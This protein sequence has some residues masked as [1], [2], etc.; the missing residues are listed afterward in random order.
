MTS[1]R[2]TVVLE[3]GLNERA[4]K[5]QN[6]NVPYGPDEVAADLVA[7]M[8]HGA[9]LVHY[10]AATTTA[11]GVGTNPELSR[12]ALDTAA[13]R[14]DLIAYPSYVE[15]I[16]RTCST[17]PI[18]RGSIASGS[19]RST[20]PTWRRRFIRRRRRDETAGQAQAL[21]ELSRRGIVPNVAAFNIG[22]PAWSISACARWAPRA[23][24]QRSSSSSARGSRG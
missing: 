8:S 19:R 17:S 23:A 18:V 22:G 20:S 24:A 4:E 16:S 9:T 7:C 13:A 21:D 6:P 12:R 15:G 3:V 10:H 11:A 5:A 14:A 1:T 2:G